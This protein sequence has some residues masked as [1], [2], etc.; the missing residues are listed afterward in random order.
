MIGIKE[1][2]PVDNALCVFRCVF[3]HEKLFFLGY[4]HNARI[5]TYGKPL[6]LPISETM[7]YQYVLNK[8]GGF[9]FINQS[10]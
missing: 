2:Y 7:Q 5:K 3:R 8:D 4:I 1:N 10:T 6:T 9:I